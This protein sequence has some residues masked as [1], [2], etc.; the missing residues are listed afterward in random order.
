MGPSQQ[1][2]EDLES[3]V[4]R[5]TCKTEASLR[6]EATVFQTEI[7]AINVGAFGEELY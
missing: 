5:S 2:E 1:V 3:G 6:L 4:N 7:I